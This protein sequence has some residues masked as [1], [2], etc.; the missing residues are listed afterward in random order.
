LT[1]VLSLLK[2]LPIFFSLSPLLVALD[3]RPEKKEKKACKLKKETKALTKEKVKILI[4]IISLKQ[5]FVEKKKQGDKSICKNS[6]KLCTNNVLS[7]R[8]NKETNIFA[9]TLLNFFIMLNS[10]RFHFLLHEKPLH[11]IPE[12]IRAC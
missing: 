5:Y 11:A 2:L 10:V 12:G 8:R 7:K 1:V 3:N 4:L 9:K 6:I